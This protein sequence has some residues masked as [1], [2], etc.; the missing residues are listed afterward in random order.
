MEIFALFS[1]WSGFY[2]ISQK[3]SIWNSTP[4]KS[5]WIGLSDDILYIV[6]IATYTAKLLPEYKEDIQKLAYSFKMSIYHFLASILTTGKSLLKKRDEYPNFCVWFTT[7][8]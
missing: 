8:I 3:G 2:H 5:L 1:K 6:T 4:I 7:E